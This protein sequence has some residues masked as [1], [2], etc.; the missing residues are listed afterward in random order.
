MESKNNLI[1]NTEKA[2]DIN[3]MIID[4]AV[5]Q[6]K[7][8]KIKSMLDVENFIDGLFQPLVQRLLNTEL[9][10]HLEYNKYEHVENKTS[11]NARNGFCKPKSVKTKYGNI[12]VKTP[13]DRNAT[14]NPI[15]VEKGQTVL[16]GFEDK[17]V[18]LYAKGMSVRDIEVVLKDIYGIN[19]NKD[20][21]TKFIAA[22]S[23]ETEK[24]RNRP[25]KPMYVFAYADCLYV[26][27]KDDITS[28]K[29]A[30]Y[31]IVGV[32]AEGY[33]EVLGMWIDRTESASFWT[34]IFEELKQRGVEDILY[35]C[36]DG[37]AGFKNSLEL[38][39]PKTN[40]Q[41]CVVHLSRNLYQI[42][43][44][45]DSKNIM[46][47]FKKIYKSV[48]LDE[49]EQNLSQFKEKYSKQKKIVNKVEEFM[50]YIEPLFELPAEIRKSIYTTNTIESVNSALRKVT[51]GKGSF[52]NEESVYKILYL[53]INDLSKK[54]KKPIRNWNIIQ[55]QL[56]E[57]Y[58]ERYTKYLN[59]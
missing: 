5:N 52:P 30:V 31:V 41:R 33:K 35:M 27:I 4:E 24:W 20:Q 34:G 44:K 40:A 50:Q 17:C 7:E 1:K 55:K 38:V 6:L 57:I 15:I 29:N 32:D 45:K 8:G 59:P 42:C 28:N 22:I 18:S 10:A 9:D 11:T 37:I 43:P 3:E 2:L 26:P 47:D 13:R 23:E 21:I 39:F 19:I 12:T 36:S 53:R 58:G 51:R 56:I 48:T 16:S 14:F 49:A 46:A 25:L 54:W